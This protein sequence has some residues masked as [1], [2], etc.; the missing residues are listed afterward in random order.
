MSLCLNV[1]FQN[2]FS[3]QKFVKQMVS[4]QKVLKQF[5]SL[6]KARDQPSFTSIQ[7]KETT[8]LL[9]IYN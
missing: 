7:S 8:M 1:V 9:Q 6:N 3:G 5:M 2:G 4:T